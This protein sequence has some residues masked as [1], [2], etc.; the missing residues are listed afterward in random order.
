MIAV[1]PFF[2]ICILLTLFNLALFSY[3]SASRESSIVKRC[4]P[5]Q[6]RTLYRIAFD[7]GFPPQPGRGIAGRALWGEY[8]YLS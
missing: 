4:S 1:R 7:H 5:S 2:V 8:D 3:A 6:F